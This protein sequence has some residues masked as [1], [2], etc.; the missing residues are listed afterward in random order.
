MSCPSRQIRWAG[1]IASTLLLALAV[2]LVVA[3]ATGPVL[4]LL[5]AF[6]L[7]VLFRRSE[8]VIEDELPDSARWS[9]GCGMEIRGVDCEYGV[10]IGVVVNDVE[11]WQIDL[12]NVA[13]SS[14]SSKVPRAACQPE[15]KRSFRP[16]RLK[17]GLY[18]CSKVNE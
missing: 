7:S 16:V 14:W 13:T 2:V 1:S 9:R 15:A 8:S 11:C 12:S 6:C 18:H 4:V 3:L 5:S 10:R 17:V